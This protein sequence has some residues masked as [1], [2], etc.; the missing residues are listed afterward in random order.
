MVSPG[1]ERF[2]SHLVKTS[3][4]VCQAVFVVHEKKVT[5]DDI[6]KFQMSGLTTKRMFDELSY[7]NHII[8]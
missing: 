8:I 7:T 4:I 1:M 5:K 3:H 6:K 2:S